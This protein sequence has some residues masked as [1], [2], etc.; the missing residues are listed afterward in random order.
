[1]LQVGTGVGAING[2][3][4]KGADALEVAC[5]VKTVVFDKTGTLTYGQPTVSRVSVFANE[6]FEKYPHV[7]ELKKTLKCLFLLLGTAETCSEHP[8]ASAICKFIKSALRLDDEH[9]ELGWANIE[10]FKNMPGL[11]LSGKIS[12]ISQQI[13]RYSDEF[14]G[15]LDT[16]ELL[17]EFRI[18]NVLVEFVKDQ[19]KGDNLAR[20]EKLETLFT[21]DDDMSMANNN[22]L[23]DDKLWEPRN[24]FL[25][26]MASESCYEILIG[27]RNWITKNG[28]TISHEMDRVLTGQEE[29]GCTSVLFA[30]NGI[31]C[32][33]VSVVDQ[34]KPEARLTVAT[35]RRMNLEVI[36]LTGDNLKTATA[37]AKQ[38]GIDNVY[39]EVLPSHKVKKIRQ[40]QLMNRDNLQE[41]G[42]AIGSRSKGI[43]GRSRKAFRNQFGAKT[44]MLKENIIAMVGDGIND[45]PALAQANVGIAISNGSDVAVE[46]ADIVLVKV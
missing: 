32:A 9:N 38:V 10:N 27:N 23:A 16:D 34:I 22:N 42:K 30:I 45:S 37:V 41:L 14:F 3:L 24:K 21:I 40:L 43:F 29:V 28:L 17:N 36:L 33:S 13:D 6:L 19:A 31:V 26:Q 46:A 25:Q 12:N 8:I 18:D 1:M 7:D 15:G 11:G 4:I 5:K 44:Q 20:P 35:L 2:I 39:A